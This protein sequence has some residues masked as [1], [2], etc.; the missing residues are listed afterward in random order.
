MKTSPSYL[1]RF[2]STIVVSSPW[3]SPPFATPII[4]TRRSPVQS[5]AAKSP[6][7][8]VV[9]GPSALT[10]YKLLFRN[11][12]THGLYLTAALKLVAA[13]RKKK[14]LERSA[15]QSR[16]FLYW[17]HVTHILRKDDEHAALLAQT[18]VLAV[19]RGHRER[20]L[21]MAFRTLHRHDHER[22][23]R[24]ALRHWKLVAP[25]LPESNAQKLKREAEEKQ[26]REE[27]A[28]AEKLAIKLTAARDIFECLK[29]L[30]R[31]RRH[32]IE[33]RR[34]LLTAQHFYFWRHAVA[35]N[36]ALTETV[37]LEADILSLRRIVAAY[38][39]LMVDLSLDIEREYSMSLPFSLA[40]YRTRKS[41]AA[42][43]AAFPPALPV[44]EPGVH[45]YN[46]KSSHHPSPEL[47]QLT[48]PFSIWT[49]DTDTLLSSSNKTLKYS[50]G[51]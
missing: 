34:M 32:R 35:E 28:R 29:G 33:S 36:H 45:V 1:S 22:R 18:Y 21:N 41:L 43:T 44:T 14:A 11:G 31:H 19:K 24:G 50:R 47:S 46:R 3:Q 23:M 42:A 25:T 17:Y 51:F 10:K 8:T 5:P 37:K 40:T 39:E 13:Y 30:V 20:I 12:I 48:A 49:K 16:G 27:E 2:D 9:S 26:R 4:L 15:L 6:A 38:E 7:K